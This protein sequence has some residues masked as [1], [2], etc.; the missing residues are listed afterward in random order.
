M[1]EK[2]LNEDT[3]CLGVEAH[4]W[5][6]AIQQGGSILEQQGVIS[7]QY[8]K[9]M[10]DAVYEYGPYIV[11]APGIALAHAKPGVEVNHVGISM[12]RLKNGIAFGSTKNDPVYIVFSLAAVDSTS[13]LNAFKELAELL[14]DETFI[15]FLFEATKLEI[16]EYIHKRN[17]N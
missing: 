10:I 9:A 14:D 3:I 13:H 6:D 5:I 16:I 1:L 2:Y 8:I 7:K 17:K 15:E 4:D 11:I 12:I